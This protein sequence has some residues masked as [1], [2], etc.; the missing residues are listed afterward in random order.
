[1]LRHVAVRAVC[2]I[3]TET[4]IVIV[5]LLAFWFKFIFS[6]AANEGR[7]YAHAKLTNEFALVSLCGVDLLSVHFNAYKTVSPLDTYH[8]EFITSRRDV[9]NHVT[10]DTLLIDHK[11]EALT[12][13][14]CDRFQETANSYLHFIFYYVQI[15]DQ[16]CCKTVPHPQ[17]CLVECYHQMD[18]RSHMINAFMDHLK[19]QML[20]E[21][22]W[23][24]N[25]SDYFAYQD[26]FTSS[27]VG[28]LL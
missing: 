10:F 15:L 27:D 4:L 28:R 23:K 6:F 26:V 22:S 16:M 12:W 20:S 21:L 5:V 2:V 8:H 7:S 3:F 14:E 19:C 1:M 24:V 11:S 18:E 13:M 9:R 25:R 17:H